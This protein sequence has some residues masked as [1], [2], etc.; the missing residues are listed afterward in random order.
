MG[1][2]QK[3]GRTQRKHF[4]ENRENTWKY[5]NH[6]DY[7]DGGDKDGDDKDGDVNS[8]SKNRDPLWEPFNTENTAFDEY[9]KVTAW[10]I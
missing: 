7:K 8:Q 3:R 4:K 5:K 9:Y 1:R 10:F 6:G 2:G